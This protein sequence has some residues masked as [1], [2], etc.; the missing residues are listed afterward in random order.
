[1]V[2]VITQ[3]LLENPVS[4]RLAELIEPVIGA[5]LDRHEAAGEDMRNFASALLMLL[6]VE[7]VA[8]IAMAP[9][10]DDRAMLEAAFLGSFEKCLAA[11]CGQGSE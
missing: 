1:M 4:R 8:A 2:T 6:A 11:A 10:G 3:T 5:E 9:N 7:A